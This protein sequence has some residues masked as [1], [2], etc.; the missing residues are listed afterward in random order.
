M[1]IFGAGGAGRAH[2]RRFAAHGDARVVCFFDPR[3]TGTI[4][5][6]PVRNTPAE[7][8]DEAD[9]VS[10]CTPD[11]THAEHAIRALD[12]GKAV[13]VEKPMVASLDH[14]GPL[15][16]ALH[17]RPEAIFAVHH[18]MRF[19]PAFAQAIDRAHAG[20]FGKIGYVA[21]SYWHD[22]RERGKEY[23]DWRIS[24]PGQSV[25]YGAACHPLD[26]IMHLLKEAPVEVAAHAGKALYPEYPGDYTVAQVTLQFPSGAIGA[27]HANNCARFPQHNDLVIL[28]ERS[29]RYDNLEFS[30]DSG[31]RFV[32]AAHPE[33]RSLRSK[34][35]THLVR[36]LLLR[37]HDLRRP[38]FSVYAHEAACA[39]VIDN[40][41][42][43]CQRREK[44]L[45][46][47]DEGAAVV[48]VCEA[49]ERSV[50]THR[51]VRPGEL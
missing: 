18:Q 13:L 24:G 46:P 34:L 35:L 29:S 40:F 4:S 21:A 25:I 44:V 16:D 51:T 50:R 36:R 3:Q 27:I 37:R 8:L 31:F 15:S 45:V 6:I 49:A 32:D 38:P 48:R 10:I 41:V 33:A 9:A 1:A 17:R 7:A 22:M 11:G 19:V 12:A 20:V 23:D 14:L 26:L 2:A 42:R 43:A 30:P 5:G 47:F 39:R 28:G